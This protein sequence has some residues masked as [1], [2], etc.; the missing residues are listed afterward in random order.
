MSFL[1]ALSAV[2][3]ARIG[4][5][6]PPPDLPPL[7]S[8]EEAAYAAA[9]PD[10]MPGPIASFDLT[11]PEQAARAR[12]L[13]GPENMAK[14]FGDGGGGTA[15]FEASLQPL[16]LM[17]TVSALALWQAERLGPGAFIAGDALAAT[18]EAT[19]EA[20][21][22]T[23]DALAA[24]SAPKAPKARKT[25]STGPAVLSGFPAELRAALALFSK[26]IEPKNTIPILSCIRLDAEG[27]NLRLTGSNLDHELSV[28]ITAPDIGEWSTAVEY[29]ALM[30]A[31]G[32]RGAVTLSVLYPE[33]PADKPVLC[34]DAEGLTTRL[35]TLLPTDMPMMEPVWGK[36]FTMAGETLRGL[37]EFTLPAVST[38][39]TRYYLNGVFL[40]A[41][42][43]GN[44]LRAVATDGHRMLLDDIPQPRGLQV[45]DWATGMIVP[46]KA[47]LALLPLIGDVISVATTKHIPINEAKGVK[48]QKV[49]THL[50]LTSGNACLTTKVIDGQY[51]DY[52]RVIP[53]A[54]DMVWDIPRAPMAEAVGKVRAVSNEKA[55]SIRLDLSPTL[56]KLTC[57]TMDGSD[58]TATIPTPIA[59]KQTLTVGLNGRYVSV[60]LQA[61]TGSTLRW[62]FASAADPVLI[63]DP[64]KPSRICILMPLRL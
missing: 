13:L 19:Q 44:R 24:A 41:P 58:A 21:E 39:E 55:Q 42:A 37:L 51:P 18:L 62:A 57:K 63:T 35:I 14:H 2:L 46:H 64:E 3:G 33:K 1:K 30:K 60:A 54:N 36:P 40:H 5:E 12:A 38:E 32:K 20:L 53:K 8:E 11:D 56:V 22:A 10:G 34:V 59:S 26:V 48:G 61:M 29:K 49:G 15:A 9:F 28:V 23:R 47:I 50:R 25:G 16:P 7:T 43:E 31:I 52:S 4:R 27:D 45:K 6:T 17:D